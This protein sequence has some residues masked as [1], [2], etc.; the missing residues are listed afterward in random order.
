MKVFH[1]LKITSKKALR[2]DCSLG[3]FLVLF[4]K[5]EQN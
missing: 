3:L 2:M 5:G 4:P 1:A